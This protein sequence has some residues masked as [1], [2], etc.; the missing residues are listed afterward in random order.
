M[1]KVVITS[2]LVCMAVSVLAYNPPTRDEIQK[3][4]KKSAEQMCQE[5]DK[6]AVRTNESEAHFK[7]SDDTRS[8]YRGTQNHYNVGGNVG[9]KIGVLGNGAK[10]GVDGGYNRDGE[11]KDHSTG[12]SVT[13][14][15]KCE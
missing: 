11:R 3:A 8:D 4:H 9:G 13:S 2:F 5:E 10:G 12:G 7:Y 6:K 15:W 14:Y 1:K